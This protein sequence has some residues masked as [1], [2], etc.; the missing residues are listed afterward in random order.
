[1]MGAQVVPPHTSKSLVLHNSRVHKPGQGTQPALGPTLVN[2]R[3][4]SNLEACSGNGRDPE[5]GIYDNL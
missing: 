3:L 5:T 4:G 1:M 2:E